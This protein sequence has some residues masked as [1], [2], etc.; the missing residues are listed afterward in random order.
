[1][2]FA[3]D[4]VKYGYTSLKYLYLCFFV[5]IDFIESYISPNFENESSSETNSIILK[6][7][8]NVFRSSAIL[9]CFLEILKN[10]IYSCSSNPTE[11]IQLGKVAFVSTKNFTVH[12]FSWLWVAVK[13][14]GN[15]MKHYLR[16]FYSACK[17]GDIIDRKL[18]EKENRNTQSK[19]HIL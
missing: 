4:I 17:H 10:I 16:I 15:W 9:I 8:P 19:Y 6:W 3:L 5:A 14:I 11:Y 18:K 12:L 1:M 13:F 7:F 2:I